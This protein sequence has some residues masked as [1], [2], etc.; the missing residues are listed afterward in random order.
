MLARD[1]ASTMSPEAT[2]K[3]NRHFSGQSRKRW[4]AGFTLIE[5]LIVIAIIAILAALL[6]PGLSAAKE[7]ARKIQCLNNQRQLTLTWMLYSGDH[8]DL[9][10]PNGYGSSSNLNGNKLWAV[11]DTHLDPASFTNLDYLMNPEFAAFAPYVKSASLYK[12]PSD[13]AKITIDSR[14]S[15]RIRSYSMNSYL[16]WTVPAGT[17]NSNIRWTFM[18]S[19]DL[20][21][22]DPSRLFLFLD[23]APASI[24]HSAFV[25][26]MGDTGWFYHRPSAE[27]RG[28]GVLTFAD[29]HAE[30]HR[31]RDPKTVELSTGGESGHFSFLPGNQ[32]LKWLQ[33]HASVLK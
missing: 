6:L 7:K 32:D 10:A 31:W 9:L 21:A 1:E 8:N 29:G 33:D 24:C 2:L 11:G 26:V 5:L 15:P 30:T 27:H 14:E 4:P 12:C 28:F 18:K 20:A 3:S 19:S 25:V 23:V 13:R 17:L 22:A 16:G